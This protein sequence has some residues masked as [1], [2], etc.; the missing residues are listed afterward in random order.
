MDFGQLATELVN[1]KLMTNVGKEI[2][3][4]FFEK[5]KECSSPKDMEGL[6]NFS[7]ERVNASLLE[8]N[9]KLPLIAAFMVASESPFYQNPK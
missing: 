1:K 9:E 5:Y 2:L 8:D 4:A 7:I 6:I 3:T